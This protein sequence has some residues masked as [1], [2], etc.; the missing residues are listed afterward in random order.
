MLWARV[1]CG[2][3]RI[4]WLLIASDSAKN[5]VLWSIS[6]GLWAFVWGISKIIGIFDLNS[7]FLGLDVGFWVGRELEFVDLDGIFGLKAWDDMEFLFS[8]DKS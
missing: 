4:R 3:F 1:Q 2:V 5:K 8:R 7:K 6:V